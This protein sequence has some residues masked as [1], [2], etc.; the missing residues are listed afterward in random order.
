M[1]KNI[2]KLIMQFSFIPFITITTLGCSQ[3][4]E[5]EEILKEKH[6]KIT[7]K[8]INNQFHVL[9]ENDKLNLNTYNNIENN[10]NDLHKNKAKSLL[11][12]TKFLYKNSQVNSKK[13]N[14]LLNF[15]NNESSKWKSKAV[16]FFSFLAISSAIGLGIYF[17]EYYSKT[18]HNLKTWFWS[19]IYN[20]NKYYL[21]TDL[22]V[23]NKNEFYKL[24][25]SLYKYKDEHKENNILLLLDK[26]IKEV[27]NLFISQI[28]FKN[29]LNGQLFIK[30][31]EEA[32]KLCNVNFI[33]ELKDIKTKLPM[34]TNAFEDPNVL[35]PFLD[36]FYTLKNSKLTLI[37]EKYKD[38][39]KEE[40]QNKITSNSQTSSKRVR[41]SLSKEN[42]QQ[43]QF[44]FWDL[45]NFNT[46][47]IN[48]LNTEE[49]KNF[50]KSNK[51]DIKKYLPLAKSILKNNLKI[52]DNNISELLDNI[53][54][55]DTVSEQSIENV[56]ETLKSK[57]I[58]DI[59]TK[60]KIVE[61]LLSQD[62]KD[63]PELQ[64]AKDIL[65]PL[66][67]RIQKLKNKS[68]YNQKIDWLIEIIINAISIYFNK[69]ENKFISYETLKELLK[70][71]LD[72]KNN[73]K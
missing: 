19:N 65:K 22:K 58:N 43:K 30:L 36:F 5:K 3:T 26:I 16:T 69:Q 18:K 31:N 70:G 57:N 25:L 68:E 34:I 61:K 28:S 49:I 29:I 72:Y 60:D 66:K 55:N 63:L 14:T 56:K 71:Y 7:L 48:N 6:A 51:E 47:N 52:E 11:S 4:K 37:N 62:I 10:I 9:N 67:N 46:N 44:N 39:F 24:L 17:E 12:E 21:F 50:L 1:L 42:S 35:G 15:F 64:M 38:I 41:R 54:K 13:T 2:S 23:E 27:L 8:L 73:K 45:L 20:K 59:L 33:T 53:I 40:T 32:K